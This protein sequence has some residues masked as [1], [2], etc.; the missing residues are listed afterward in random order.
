MQDFEK[1]LTRIFEFLSQNF[2]R[3][4][5]ELGKIMLTKFLLRILQDYSCKLFSCRQF[6]LG[7][8]LQELCNTFKNTA[9]LFVWILARCQLWLCL[10][11]DF[12]MYF[13][14]ICIYLS[15][16]TKLIVS[17]S[18]Q[19]VILTQGLEPESWNKCY[20]VIRE[21][22]S[23]NIWDVSQECNVGL[24]RVFSRSDGQG[25]TV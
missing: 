1:I 13:F 9:G 24:W 17:K 25:S 18:D 5:K 12:V 8:N 4:S 19:E 16:L 21:E 7:G 22:P 6:D 23:P 20:N 11:F 3:T 15:Q 2:I 14:I 10:C